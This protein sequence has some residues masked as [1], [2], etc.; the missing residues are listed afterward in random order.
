MNCF[1]CNSTLSSNNFC[2]S[3]GT[4]VTVYKKIVKMSNTY[5]N[6]GL[7]KAQIRDLSGA[8]D[9]LRR[10]VRLYK[11][12]TKARNL[13]GLVYFEMGE[14]VQALSEWVISKNLQPEK[15]I[16]DDYIRAVQSNQTRLETIN[17]T[18][19]KYNLAL[20]YATQG[21]DDLAVIQLKKVLTLNPNLVKGHQLLGLLYMKRGDYDKARKSINKSLKIDSNNTLSLRYQKEIDAVSEDKTIMA[22]DD[23][24][25]KSDAGKDYLSG[26][27]VIIPPTTYK[28]YNSGA[29][30]ILHY[31]IGIIIGALVIYLLIM[32]AKVKD[33]KD[34]AN[35]TV[36]EYSQKMSKITAENEDLTNQLTSITEERD[37]LQTDLA[38][39]TGQTGKVATYENMVTAMKAYLA[40]DYKTGADALASIDTSV[41][42]SDSFTALYTTLHDDMYKKAADLYYDDGMTA[43]NSKNW[44]AAIDAM[45]KCFK[46]DA[47][48][49]NALYYT[50]RSYLSNGDSANA[51]IY[52]NKIITEFPDSS[53]AGYAES[54]IQ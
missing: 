20:S 42:I 22:G 21:S 47:T 35:D 23:S 1:K 48:N 8:A 7:A 17:Q 33:Y 9:L 13:L 30:T 31:V 25:R 6:M 27:D 37:K 28:D 54:Y 5:Y 4:D 24:K 44:A 46:Y 15:N 14:A 43:Y 38:S 40:Q 29:L 51:N 2:N 49:V 53:Q 18:I 10:S 45:I 41:T 52:F 11:K 19:K 3:C 12:N 16:A 34:Q 36:K 26:N 39:V 50:G 32:P